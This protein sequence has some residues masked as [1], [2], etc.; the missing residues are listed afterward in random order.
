[1]AEEI[2]KEV[3]TKYRKDIVMLDGL[4]QWALNP[5]SMSAGYGIE[6][7]YPYIE[8][9]L[10]IVHELTS[11]EANEAVETLRLECNKFLEFQKNKYDIDNYQKIIRDELSKLEYIK[12]FENLLLKRSKKSNKN[13]IRFLNL[14]KNCPV[15]NYS[16]LNVQYNAIYGEEIQEEDIIHLSILKPLYW[17]SSGKSRNTE[18]IPK[19]VPF[20]DSIMDKLKL[21]KWKPDTP[22]IKDFIETL[23]MTYNINTLNFLK[24]LFER[25]ELYTLIYKK[26]QKI[27][28]QKGITG[29]YSSHNP[30][31]AYVGISFLIQKELFSLIKEYIVEELK[32]KTQK[33]IKILEYEIKDGQQPSDKEMIKF[34]DVH[35]S[36]I[37]EYEMLINVLPSESFSD[38]QDISNK[39]DEAIK[40]FDVPSLYDL[41]KTLQYDIKSARRVGKYLIDSN[42]IKELARVPKEVA[43]STPLKPS[44]RSSKFEN[45]ICNMCKT[46][47]S[48]RENPVFCPYCGSSDLLFK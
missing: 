2:I 4:L 38:D 46:P 18:I 33:V 11:S 41:L 34:C 21:K 26:G 8:R 12:L 40:Q 47:L 25:N 48:D 15:Q 32:E 14:Y 45:I 17:I 44:V 24:D 43:S 29:I 30:E 6:E 7:N 35:I 37:N 13:A 22:N 3:I 16:C 10:K 23:K 20:L 27:T 9:N 36:E 42:M 39:A 28:I 5:T 19:Y 31:F 1:M